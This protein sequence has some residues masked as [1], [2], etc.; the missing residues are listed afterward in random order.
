MKM[1]F[2]RIICIL[3]AAIMTC[4]LFACG[5]D[6]KTEQNSTDGA[7]DGTERSKNDT[8]SGGDEVYVP[9]RVDDAKARI[10]WAEDTYCAFVVFDASPRAGIRNVDISSISSAD[11]NSTYYA[12]DVYKNETRDDG[13]WYFFMSF[14]DEPRTVE[15]YGKFNIEITD[16]ATGHERITNLTDLE[17]IT[18]EELEAL[19]LY[20]AGGHPVISVPNTLYIDNDYVGFRAHFYVFGKEGI[21][22]NSFTVDHFAFFAG[23][24]T[25]ITDMFPNNEFSIKVVPPYDIVYDYEV[26]ALFELSSSDE[27]EAVAEQLKSCDPYIVYTGS[28]GDTWS[29]PL[30]V[31]EE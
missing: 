11:G 28:D 29:A 15:D 14:R 31:N 24:G 12:V 5:Q 17:M 26:T 19:G 2:K 6:G 4:A 10:L 13:I 27:A 16:T 25:P 1:Q 8:A 30:L 21:D 18:P 7:G 23:D 22:E 3:L 20:S 9:P